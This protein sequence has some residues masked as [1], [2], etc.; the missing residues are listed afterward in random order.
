MK[1]FL[2]F[3]LCFGFTSASAQ[4]VPFFLDL[5]EVNAPD[6]PAIHSFAKAQSGDKWLIVGGRIDGL[7]SLFPNLS[8]SFSEQN[9]NIFVIDTSTWNMWQSS[10]YN[11]LYQ[12]RQSL[13]ATNTEFFQR[14]NYLYVIGGFGYDSLND[15]KKTFS[16]LTA[17]DV[18]G[19]INEIVNGGNSLTQYI[20]QISDTMF[21]I[22]GGKMQNIG[23]K[24]YLAGGQNFSGLYTKLNAG[25]Y[26]QHYT[27]SI[28]SFDLA[29]DGVNLL[30]SNFI[31]NVDT[32]NL[33]RR[34]LNAAPWISENNEEGFGVYGGVFQ[35]DHNT[36]YQNP[37]YVTQGGNEIDFSFEQ[38]MSQY[39]CPVI[40]LYDSVTNDMYSI[41]VAG[42]SLYYLD[43]ATQTLTEDTLVPFIKDISTLIHHANGTT[44]EVLLPIQF[45][46][47]GGTNAEFFQNASLEQYENGVIKLRTFTEPTLLGYIFGG[48]TSIAGNDGVTSPSNKC[49]RVILEPDFGSNTTSITSE[50]KW[51]LYPNPSSDAVQLILKFPSS[52]LSE[53]KIVDALNHEMMKMYLPV[54]FTRIKIDT[55]NFPAG[56]YSV[57]VRATSKS[58]V[59]RLAV[60]K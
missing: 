43:S 36:P 1:N 60:V 37:I 31:M 5:Q 30:A 33:H 57:I 47:L 10:L 32:E 54:S 55:R 18:N 23:D 16:T 40:P 11:T 53:V 27:N 8:F 20:R 21:T 9:N 59:T 38:K 6:L 29:D 46:E 12:V 49:Y 26:V 25:L 7:H 58:F 45:P 17:L 51:R 13:S 19:L 52:E 42:M 44:D 28:T 4:S 3:I 14:G 41:F 24:L 48:M 50:K 56:I 39:Q 35:Y 15:E 34:D 22:T 2:L